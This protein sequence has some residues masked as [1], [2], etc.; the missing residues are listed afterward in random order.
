[1]QIEREFSG[2]YDG[3]IELKYAAHFFITSAVKHEY[4]PF[5]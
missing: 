4:K 3:T 2:E 5:F 1:M